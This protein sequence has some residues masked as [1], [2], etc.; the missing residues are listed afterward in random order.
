[1]ILFQTVLS[2]ACWIF[3]AWSLVQWLHARSMR[4]A[5]F[6]VIILLGMSEPIMVWE[7]CLLSESVSTSLLAAMI[8]AWLL[9]F[10]F[11]HLD[12]GIRSRDLYRCTGLAP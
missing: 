11:I 4:I 5:A 1:V 6:M 2:L 7:S 3:L 12:A 9:F 10:P 8:G